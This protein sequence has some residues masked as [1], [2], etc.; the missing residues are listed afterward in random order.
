MLMPNNWLA[1]P[2]S[3]SL[4]FTCNTDSDGYFVYGRP[5]VYVTNVQIQY[6][7]LEIMGELYKIKKFFLNSS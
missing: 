5:I 3:D 7:E 4:V 1:Y 6:N 2:K